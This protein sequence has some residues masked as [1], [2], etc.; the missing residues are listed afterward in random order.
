ML[1]SHEFRRTARVVRDALS[2]VF[3]NTADSS[4]HTQIFHGEMGGPEGND[5]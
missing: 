2:I 3:R 5:D 4:R 1:L